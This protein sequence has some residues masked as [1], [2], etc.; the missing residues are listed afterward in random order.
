MASG[1]LRMSKG[2]WVSLWVLCGELFS[3]GIIGMVGGLGCRE[4]SWDDYDE[5]ILC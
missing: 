5:G 3:W 1:F 2:V 4:R